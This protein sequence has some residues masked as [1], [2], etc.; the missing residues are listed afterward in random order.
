MSSW[1]SF[2]IVR[3][4]SLG[5]SVG[6]AV[7]CFVDLFRGTFCFVPSRP[8]ST[9]WREFSTDRKTTKPWPKALHRCNRQNVGSTPFVF[10]IYFIYVLPTACV[11]CNSCILGLL[12]ILT[13]AELGIPKRTPCLPS[14]LTGI[15]K[16]WGF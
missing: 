13:H 9:V 15:R 11:C 10:C 4:G 3:V 16:Q 5:F 14:E 7:G 8:F 6:P 1:L 2:H 12:D